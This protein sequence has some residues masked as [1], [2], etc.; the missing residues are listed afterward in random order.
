MVAI[1]FPA[2][3]VLGQEFIAAGIR[4][5]WNGYGWVV[6]PASAD[7]AEAFVLTTGD[8]MTGDLIIHKGNPAFT[9]NKNAAG[10]RNSLRGQT[11]GV[12]RW[13]VQ[14]GDITAEAGGHSGSDFVV[15]AYNDSGVLSS[16]PIRIDRLTGLAKVVADPLVPL[17]VATKQYVDAKPS[18][19][20]STLAEARAGIID[21]KAVS[22][23]GHRYSH[24]PAFQAVSGPMGI[25]PNTYTAVTTFGESLDT[26]NCFNGVSFRPNVAGWYDIGGTINMPT[27]GVNY[28]SVILWVNAGGTYYG[29]QTSQGSVQTI[30]M[31]ARGVLHFNGTSDYVELVGLSDHPVGRFNAAHFWGY[32]LF[33]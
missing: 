23:Y 8:T 19:P 7:S 24:S 9:L 5:A 21:T 26:D 13:R 33:A 25:S 20:I 4:Y 17:G 3:P 22:P 29:T 16:T 15:E 2:A 11:N 30:M 31:Q 27:L 12:D 1:D 32:R 6:V 28:C 14:L 10:E 18:T